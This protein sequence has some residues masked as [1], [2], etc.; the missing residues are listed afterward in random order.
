MTSVHKESVA[1]AAD[2]SGSPAPRLA[3]GIAGPIAVVL[4]LL[5][6]VL[7]FVVLTDLT[8][9]EPTQIVVSGVLLVNAV[10]MLV[11]LFIIAR[12]VWQIVQARRRGR[13]GA[14]L[15]V[16]IVGLF[17]VIA[18]APAILLGLAASMTLASG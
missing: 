10:M 14:K 2:A 8:P 7:T 12:E 6:A 5:W 13:A 17:S 16:R 4:A 3:T 11:L 18:V 1:D 9:I 15:H